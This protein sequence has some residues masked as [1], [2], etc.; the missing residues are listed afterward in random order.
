MGT[1]E[2]SNVIEGGQTN[3]IPCDNQNDDRRRSGPATGQIAV[4]RQAGT[5]DR[6]GRHAACGI[7]SRVFLFDRMLT[8]QQAS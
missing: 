7:K 4:V 1:K 8:N 6:C 2:I 5:R 3:H